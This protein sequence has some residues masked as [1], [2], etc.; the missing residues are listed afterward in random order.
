MKRI[1][2]LIAVAAMLMGAFAVYAQEPT[3]GSGGPVVEGDLGGSVNFGSLMPLR[4]NDS[5]TNRIF[6]LMFPT[7]I[8][9]SPITQNYALAGDEGVTG[10]LATS[11]DVSDDGLTYTF[12]LR[13]DAYW[14]DGE[15][16]T[17]WDVKFSF[18]AIASG[19]IDAP[20]YGLLNYVAD[21]NPVG[22]KE[23]NVLD[24]YTYEAVFE[25]AS[26]TALGN[27]A[28][29][30]VTPSH[31]WNYDGSP[32]FDFS[33]L[34]DDPFDTNPSVA[35]G[36]FEF[37]SFNPGEAV[38]VKATS[39]WADGTVVPSGFIYRDVPDATVL[40][41]Q[42]LAGE[43]NFVDGPTQSRRADIRAA[44]NINSYDFPGL[45]SW[46]YMG[47]NLADPT[48]PQPGLDADGNPIDQGHHPIFG[49]VRVRR[50]IQMATDVQGIIDSAVF[51][52]GTQMAA[53]MAPSSWA[54]DPNLAPV[55][56]DPEGAAALLDEAGWPVGPD[57]VR[58]CQGC[59]YAEE[60]TPFEFS[61]I[62]NQ[63]NTRRETIGVVIQDELYD[64]GI[65]VDFQAI[66]FN[67]LID[68][69]FGAQTFDAY[70]LGWGGGFPSDP[71]QTQFWS[72]SND[73][74]SNS[75]SNATSYNN[76]KLNELMIQAA[77][78]PGCD[79]AA[80]AEIYH[81]IEK[82][83]QD[84]QPYVWLYVQNNMYAANKDVVGFE[85]YNNVPLWNIH[86]WVI[87]SN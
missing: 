3:T 74:P 34:V 66:D 52:E 41:E 83:L 6:S 29:F 18:D 75:S 10:A 28:G 70:I 46:D 61:L 36:P 30:W 78:V 76:P 21:G 12:H 65:T 77:T 48:N 25:Q 38:A 27:A 45:S 39:N 40:V 1:V 5:A 47:F 79:P 13:N 72:P 7:V 62:T 60:G 31:V 84:D 17:A 16:I 87:S 22:V 82:I 19:V 71:D 58:I 50:A 8:G 85:P 23:I 9:A 2:I 64:L 4:S 55:P 80:R 14:N 54:K 51:G 43:L 32:D 24:D 33:V 57:G 49:D 20:L 73:D 53:N 67:T 68:E 69:T 59:M 81:Q 11:Y 56:Y 44:A 15:P 35:Y 37:A 42:F 63:G 86:T 26:C